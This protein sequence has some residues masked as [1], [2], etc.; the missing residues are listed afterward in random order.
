[1]IS[2]AFEYSLV[3]KLAYLVA[4][5]ASIYLKIISKLLTVEGDVEGAACRLLRLMIQVC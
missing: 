2:I 5:T 3:T 4:Q 1:M